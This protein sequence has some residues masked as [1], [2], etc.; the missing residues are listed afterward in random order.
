M[1]SAFL[2]LWSPRSRDIDVKPGGRY[3]RRRRDNVTEFATVMEL[4]PDAIGIPHVR[5]ALVFEKPSIGRVEAGLRMLA[6]N[7]FVAAYCHRV[8]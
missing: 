3:F 2:N 6:L 4:K 8:G 1:P 7:A 5:F